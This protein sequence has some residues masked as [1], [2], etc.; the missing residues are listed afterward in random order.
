MFTGIFVVNDKY[1]V[2]HSLFKEVTTYFKE[3]DF[4]YSMIILKV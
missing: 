3:L 2:A 4:I 1:L